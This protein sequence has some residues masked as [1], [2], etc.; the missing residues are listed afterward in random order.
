MPKYMLPVKGLTKM[1]RFQI[2]WQFVPYKAGIFIEELA[3]ER[4]GSLPYANG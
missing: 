4:C 3:W 2:G 1:S